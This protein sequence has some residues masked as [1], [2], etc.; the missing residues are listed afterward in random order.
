MP[1]GITG[2]RFRSSAVDLLWH[3]LEYRCYL[4]RDTFLFSTLPPTPELAVSLLSYLITITGRFCGPQDQS[5]ATGT[6]I[7]H[8]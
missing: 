8:N 1:D 6:F 2:L 4:T 3:W 7:R 5:V